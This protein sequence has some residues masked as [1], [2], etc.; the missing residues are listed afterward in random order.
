MA[1]RDEENGSSPRRVFGGMLKYYRARAGLSQ[2]QLGSRVY[3]S[4]DMI[5]KIEKGD[6]APTDQFI[7]ACEA[8]PEL[9]ANGALRELREQLRD[10]LQQRAYPGWFADWPRKEAQAATLRSFQPLV[11]PGLLQTED[12]ARAV[13]RTRVGDTDAEVEEMVAARLDRQAI[14]DRDKPPTLWVIL[15]EGVLRRPVGGPAVMGEQ[16]RHLAKAAQRPSIVLQVIPAATGAHQGLNG[17]AFV[18]ADFAEDDGP[19]VGYVDTAVAGQIVESADGIRSLAATWD[20]LKSE[21][22]PRGASLALVE[23]AAGQWRRQES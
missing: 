18:I 17:G 9:E 10:Y 2:E 8:I 23:E 21:A 5:G 19:A 12:Y 20:T 3:L 16:L 4:S 1:G 6:R 11:V 15:D 7:T 13:L 14:L 22:L